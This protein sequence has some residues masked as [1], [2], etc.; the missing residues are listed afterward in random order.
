MLTINDAPQDVLEDHVHCFTTTAAD[1]LAASLAPAFKA[2][3]TDWT[4]VNGLR[5]QLL[6]GIAQAIAHA[7]QVDVQLNRFVDDLVNLLQKITKKDKDDPVW[8]VY[9]NG[10]EPG[11]VKKPISS[12]FTTPAAG[13]PTRPE[14]RRRSRRRSN[15]SLAR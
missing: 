2:Q 4:G 11:Q 13:A 14:A 7:F 15:R 9:L 8:T 1:P 3:I 12:S 6:I 10:Q 5:I